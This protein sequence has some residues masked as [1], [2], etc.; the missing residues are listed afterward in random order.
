MK[1]RRLFSRLFDLLTDY[2]GIGA[3]RPSLGQQVRISIVLPYLVFYRH[4]ESDDTVTILRIVHGRR[5]IT[6]ALIGGRS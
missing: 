6:R 5:N 4:S 3:S 2:P 1:Y